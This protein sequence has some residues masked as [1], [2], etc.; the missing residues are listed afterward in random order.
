MKYYALL[1]V[2]AIALPALLASC[3]KPAYQVRGYASY[4]A[5]QYA[6][7]YT[8]SGAIYQPLGWTAAHNTLP[9]GTVVKVKNN[10]NGRTVNVTVNDRFP[11]YPNR[12]INLSRAAAQELQ[13]PY[14]Q[15][16]DVT[17]TAKTIAGGA[18]PAANY[19][20]PPAAN[21]GSNYGATAPA[22][23]A[24]PPSY[25]P[26]PAVKTYSNPTA[27][28]PAGYGTSAPPAGIPPPPPGYR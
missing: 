11:S 15:P 25:T 2:L 5:E 6:G 14:H 26:P 8:S 21:Y 13:I 18:A 3:A 27:V 9:F 19:G 10:Y 23:Y 12:V 28:P 24:A 16:G 7:R 4:I 17:V 22:N 20:N 1:R